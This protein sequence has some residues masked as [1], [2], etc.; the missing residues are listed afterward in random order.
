MEQIT[1][2]SYNRLL[3]ERCQLAS[4]VN[5]IM[6]ALGWQPKGSGWIAP[7][8]GGGFVELADPVV[9]AKMAADTVTHQRELLE[10][11]RT[12]VEV[13]HLKLV[14]SGPDVENISTGGAF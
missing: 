7:I 1:I 5:Q 10:R 9:A 2:E 12:P 8:P 4:Q 13:P 3:E 14:S 11:L 6:A